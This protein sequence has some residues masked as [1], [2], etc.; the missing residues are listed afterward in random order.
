M[1]T[2]DAAN[3]RQHRSAVPARIGRDQLIGCCGVVVA[4]NGFA[5]SLVKAVHKQPLDMALLDLG[6][7]SAIAWFAICAL[8]LIGAE[9]GERE[10]VQHGDIAIAAVMLLLALVPFNQ[11]GS[12]GLLLGGLHLY[13]TAQRG[14]RSR[15]IAVVMLGLT[16][17]LIWGRLLL[18][19]F[20]PRILGVDAHIAAFFAGL[21]VRGNVVWFADGRGMLYVALGC[22]SIHNISLAILLFVTLMQLLG[23]RLTLARLGVGIV[24]AGAMALVNVVRLATLARFPAQFDY[25]HTGP[26]A[27][28][29]GI[30]GFLITGVVMVVGLGLSARRR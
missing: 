2:Q 28:F 29:F 15:R 20:G 5:G 11:A 1:R 21:P 14:S 8:L 19:F 24:A 18:A 23:L 16:G 25:I 17:P 10:P 13:R 9:R 12:A 22:S 3:L 30:A 4:V 6:G 7:I 27:Q 26:G